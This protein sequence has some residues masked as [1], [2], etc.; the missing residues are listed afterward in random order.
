VALPELCFE[1]AGKSHSVELVF[2]ANIPDGLDRGSEACLG[3]ECAL[4]VAYHGQHGQKLL[5]QK[6]ALASSLR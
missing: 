5:Y 1:L 4:V 6:I 2:S 3:L